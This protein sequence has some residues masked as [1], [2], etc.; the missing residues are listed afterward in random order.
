V[1]VDGSVQDSSDRDTR[2][3]VEARIPFADLKVR[4][5]AS[6]DVW[7]GSFY[8]FNRDRDGEPEP[9]SCHPPS[10]RAFISHHALAICGSNYD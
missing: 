1:K 6:G 10:F 4:T 9:L 2:W 8:R 5:P 3:T 7:R